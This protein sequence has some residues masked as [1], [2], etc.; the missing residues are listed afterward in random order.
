MTRQQLLDIAF[1]QGEFQKANHKS[2]SAFRHYAAI[3]GIAERQ[4]IQHYQQQI[5]PEFLLILN[6]E[7]TDDSTP[8]AWDFSATASTNSNII[9]LDGEV[10]KRKD[11]VHH[12][13]WKEGFFFDVRKGR[14]IQCHH[15]NQSIYYLVAFKD[16]TFL[17]DV[18][19]FE[20][21]HQQQQFP[22]N[23]FRTP[24][25]RYMPNEG[26][27]LPSTHNYN[28]VLASAAKE[29]QWRLQMHREWMEMHD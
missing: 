24:I 20:Q 5:P 18:T 17:C 10:K 27:L 16:Y 15:R 6:L 23:R 25:A 12:N 29:Y 2:N 13:T 19:D 3:H 7:F 9:T 1:L 22:Q 8:F 14:S 4:I 11:N 28:D 21:R 26:I